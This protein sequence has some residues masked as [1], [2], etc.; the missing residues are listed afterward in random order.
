MGYEVV[1]PSDDDR[2][3]YQAIYDVSG[4]GGL[5]DELIGRLAPGG[6]ITLAGF[7]SD[8][9][10]FAFAP[11]F[12]REARI[13]IA[14]QWHRSDLATVKMFAESGCLSLDGLIS[15]E[16]GA[17]D[18]VSAYETAFTDPTCLKMV[19]DWRGNA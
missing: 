3:N 15:H 4:D 13:R 10:S 6:E 12:M 16:Q 8:P 5:L 1:D 11:A 2:R 18:A 7:Y 14:A 17:G 19:L 9:L